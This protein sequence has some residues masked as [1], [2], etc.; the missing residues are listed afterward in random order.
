VI[1]DFY[2]LRSFQHL[3]LLIFFCSFSLN[4]PIATCSLLFLLSLHA[5]RW[6]VYLLIGGRL[7]HR[8]Q[9]VLTYGGRVLQVDSRH[10]TGD[11]RR[12]QDCQRDTRLSAGRRRVRRRPPTTARGRLPPVHRVRH[13]VHDHFGVSFT[14]L[15]S[16][17]RRFLHRAPFRSVTRRRLP[18]GPLP[19]VNRPSGESSPIADDGGRRV[20]LK[21]PDWRYINITTP[22]ARMVAQDTYKNKYV[23]I[24]KTSSTKLSIDNNDDYN[25]TFTI[26]ELKKTR[27]NIFK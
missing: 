5:D 18:R 24:R 6:H 27:F 26:W 17:R 12:G 8:R 14:R 7:K 22:H 3:L 23:T 15:R 13:P 11:H 20:R 25:V 2:L 9:P 16:D 10:G 19:L 1:C 4:K 21:N